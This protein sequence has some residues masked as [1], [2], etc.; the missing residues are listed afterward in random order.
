MTRRK[1]NDSAA[2][3]QAQL[4]TRQRLAVL[5]NGFLPVPVVG[6]QSFLKD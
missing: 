6:K 4:A 3:K 5:A 2:T 1:P